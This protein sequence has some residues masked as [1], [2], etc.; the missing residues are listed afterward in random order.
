M[1]QVFPKGK[2]IQVLWAKTLNKYWYRFY[3][4]GF[5]VEIASL[6]ISELKAYNYF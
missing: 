4:L 6:L 3:N 5:V 2:F 1:A